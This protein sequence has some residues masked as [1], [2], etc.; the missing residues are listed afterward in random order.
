MGT[1][2]ISTGAA[3]A[4]ACALTRAWLRLY[5]WGMPSE[6]ADARRAEVESDLWEMQHDPKLRPGWWQTAIAIDRLMCGM[7]DDL[8]WR[9]DYARLEEQV[10]ARQAIAL[11]LAAIVVLGL[12]SAPALLYEHRADV[13]DCA[14]A[15]PKPRI[16]PIDFEII[17]CV[18][19]FFYLPPDVEI[20][21]AGW[22]LAGLSAD[23]ATKL[24]RVSPTRGFTRPAASRSDPAAPRAA[25]ESTPPDR[26]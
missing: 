9:F 8:A 1:G 11:A 14:R 10:V 17:R 22:Q 20:G 24:T 18:G 25:L 12:W 6:I 15:V 19:A 16:S 4:I 21:S 13:S 5:T 7:A 2:M 23:P 26:R 3:V